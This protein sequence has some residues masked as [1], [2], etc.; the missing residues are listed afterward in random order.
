MV[1]RFRELGCTD[2]GIVQANAFEKH[3]RLDKKSDNLLFKR[4]VTMLPQVAPRKGKKKKGDGKKK[5]D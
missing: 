4:F 2:D 1:R 3:S 5:G